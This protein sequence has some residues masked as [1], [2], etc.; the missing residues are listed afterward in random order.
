MRTVW[1]LGLLWA[2]LV[3]ELGA[4]AE[5]SEAAI[6]YVQ[7]EGDSVEWSCPFSFGRHATSKKALQR[8]IDGAEPLTMARIEKPSGEPIQV[9]TGRITLEEVPH[10]TVLK[11][12]ITNLQV[13][14]SGLYQCVAYDPP[15]D[16]ELLAFRVHLVVAKGITA[17]DKN[18][19]EILPETTRV[20]P[21]TI[22][23]LTPPY[24]SSS[25]IT[26]APFRSTTV[27]STPGPG[28]TLQNVT[29]VTRVSVFSIVVPVACG[30]LTKSLVFTV[31]LAVTRSHFDCR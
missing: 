3:S 28:V 17:S 24:T 8:L 26:Q 19:T 23:A 13:E 15:V 20:P 25:T 22:E 18:P 11:V 10:D 7:R 27:I 21:T 29:N 9:Q 2:L 12:R 6:K 31:L 30:L 5:S 1:L 16:P 14:D 4:A